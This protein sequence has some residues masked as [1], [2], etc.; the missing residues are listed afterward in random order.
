MTKSPSPVELEHSTSASTQGSWGR[1]RNAHRRSPTRTWRP[2]E[3][4]ETIRVLESEQMA[5]TTFIC[6][7]RR[8][9]NGPVQA[10]AGCVGRVAPRVFQVEASGFTTIAEFN[11]FNDCYWHSHDV[12]PAGDPFNVRNTWRRE[13]PFAIATRSI[14]VITLRVAGTWT[15]R[16]QFN[17]VQLAPP[18]P[19]Q[20]WYD[21]QFAD[22]F[23]EQWLPDKWNCEHAGQSPGWNTPAPASVSLRVGLYERIPAN[24]CS[25]A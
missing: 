21:K 11:G 8:Y 25:G 6:V 23:P 19:Q 16:V 18:G 3:G 24:S 9:P 4:V 22:G 5:E 14:H 20:R 7:G 12:F 10:Q 1:Y 2:R 13:P 17:I 15:T